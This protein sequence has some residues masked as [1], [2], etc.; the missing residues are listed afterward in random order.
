MAAYDRCPM[1]KRPFLDC[2]HSVPQV[3]K[4]QFK[5]EM[6]KLIKKVMK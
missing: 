3:E 1:C 2:N 5:Q 6:M 4:W